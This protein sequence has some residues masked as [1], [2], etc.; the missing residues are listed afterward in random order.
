MRRIALL[1]F[2]F[3]FLFPIAFLLATSFKTPDQAML[4]AFF[5]TQPVTENWSTAFQRIALLTF[6]RNSVVSACAAGLLTLAIS[7]P[8]VYAVEKL[9][10]ARNW[11]PDVV[12]GVYLAPPIVALLLGVVMAI[13]VSVLGVIRGGAEIALVVSMTMVCVVMVGSLIGMSL[14]FALSRMKLD[15][16]TASAPLITSIADAAGVLIY[17]GIATAMLPSLAEMAAAG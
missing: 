2:L 6:L 8:A 17:F 4:G 11:L 7:V 9:R 1:A 16:A 14:P 10:T 12:L 3:F 15:P 13:A 5:P